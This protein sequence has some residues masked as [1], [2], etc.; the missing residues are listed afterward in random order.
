M[1]ETHLEFTLSSENIVTSDSYVIQIS[2]TLSSLTELSTEIIIPILNRV[3]GSHAGQKKL[4]EILPLIM[5]DNILE[6]IQLIKD[7]SKDINISNIRFKT[8]NA[9]IKRE[10]NH[11]GFE[12]NPKLEN[13]KTKKKKGLFG[14]LRK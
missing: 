13:M 6:L 3:I 11:D 14:F 7:D 4:E 12:I 10:H 9:E 5:E 8:L 2:G 1:H